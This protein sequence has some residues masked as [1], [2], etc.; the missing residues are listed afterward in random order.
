MPP[1][2]FV[3]RFRYQYIKYSKQNIIGTYKHKSLDGIICEQI[4]KHYRQSVSFLPH[5]ILHHF[6]GESALAGSP[7]VFFLPI[8]Q[9]L[10]SSTC[11]TTERLRISGT[12]LTVGRMSFLSSNLQCPST[13][14]TS[15]SGLT[16]SLLH[17]PLDS[18]WKGHCSIHT[19]STMPVLNM[20]ALGMNTNQLILDQKQHKRHR[21]IDT[22]SNFNSSARTSFSVA[23]SNDLKA[24]NYVQF[25]DK[26]VVIHQKN[27]QLSSS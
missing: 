7:S 13:E 26:K 23:S 25:T 6:P 19:N 17:P 2:S 11:S 20:K 15:A 16:S 21:Q 5:D 24:H 27:K 14:E 18:R 12:G 4:W 1:L 9:H 8:V 3:L 22:F 10:S